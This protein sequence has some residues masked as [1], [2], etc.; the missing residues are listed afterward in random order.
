M[1]LI[2]VGQRAVYLI[3]WYMVML[4]GVIGL[5]ICYNYYCCFHEA[6]NFRYIPLYS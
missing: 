4:N 6:T 3:R 5:Y 1:K 2:G